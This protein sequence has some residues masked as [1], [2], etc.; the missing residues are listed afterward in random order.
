MFLPRLFNRG[1]SLTWLLYP[2][3]GFPEAENSI[4]GLRLKH[5]VAVPASSSGD[6]EN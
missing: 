4:A 6:V 5:S 3:Q 2:A 1:V